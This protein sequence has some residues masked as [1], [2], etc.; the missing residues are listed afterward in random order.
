MKYTYLDLKDKVET[1]D[2]R[3][4]EVSTVERKREHFEHAYRKLYGDDQSWIDLG[5]CKGNQKA[6]RNHGKTIE[7]LAEGKDP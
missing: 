6:R 2:G 7:S 1:P 4:Y 3:S 5:K